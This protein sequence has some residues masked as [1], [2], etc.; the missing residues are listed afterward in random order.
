MVAASEKTPPPLPA[1]GAVP[2]TWPR[3]TMVSWYR[4]SQTRRRTVPIDWF[5]QNTPPFPLA[6][7]VV[8]PVLQQQQ[9]C[10]RAA[11]HARPQD[12]GLN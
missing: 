9:N 3:S 2:M 10:G 6:W 1:P 5:E 4:H 11:G 7:F 12:T 8:S